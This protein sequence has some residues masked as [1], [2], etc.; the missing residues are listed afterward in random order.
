MVGTEP[1]V[2]VVSMGGV[3]STTLMDFF[4]GQPDVV[5]NEPHGRINPRK[6]AL[7]PPHDLPS[8]E[9][10][11]FLFGCPY[12][13]LLSLFRR[14]YADA[15]FVTVSGLAPPGLSWPPD[16]WTETCRRFG[17]REIG[18]TN[19]WVDAEGRHASH[20]GAI[21]WFRKHKAQVEQERQRSTACV[22]RIARGAFKDFDDYLARGV[23]L[24][25]WGEQVEHWTQEA[26]PYPILTLRY[27]TLW[28]HLPELFAFMNVP[29]ERIDSFP[30]H[31]PRA[32]DHRALSSHQREL[33]QRLYGTLK[34]RIDS[35]PDVLER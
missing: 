4:A 34:Q 21:E 35:L 8:V 11:L 14:G 28:D 31:R 19:Q 13:S 17:L 26:G 25:R 32:S 5:I 10:A 6:H 20:I 3:G 15:H 9:R 18:Q 1:N 30:E 27:E 22:E 29:A 16:P 23:D 7:C 2:L 24:L 33:L 12:D